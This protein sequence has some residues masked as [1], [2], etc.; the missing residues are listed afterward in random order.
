MPL[1]PLQPDQS[2]LKFQA[3]HL[4]YCDIFLPLFFPFKVSQMRRIK[5]NT[6]SC[7]KEKIG[8]ML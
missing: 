5:L 6:Q 8:K 3:I 7:F 2:R 4:T 1:F